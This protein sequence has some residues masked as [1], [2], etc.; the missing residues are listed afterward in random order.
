MY[1]YAHP[2]I[3]HG[4]VSFA[5]HILECHVSNTTRRSRSLACIFSHVKG[6]FQ[7]QGG[8]EKYL[9]AFPDGGHWRGKNFVFD[10][11][12][13][14]GVDDLNGVG[15]VT[16]KQKK[17]SKAKAKGKGKGKGKGGNDDGD[18]GG[19][20]GRCCVCKDEW[21][22]YVLMTHTDRSTRTAKNVL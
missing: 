20:L 19:V 7:L 4:S 2:G 18:G 5:T 13:A 6:I 22:R 9:K 8:I 15:G 10:K 17:K 12:E 21:N 3:H 14:F 16:G 11:R 1:L